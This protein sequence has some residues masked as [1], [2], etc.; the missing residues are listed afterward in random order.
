M[1][2]GIIECFVFSVLT[3]LIPLDPDKSN[4]RITVMRIESGCPWR[5]KSPTYEVFTMLE[6]L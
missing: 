3:T 4:K 2:L 6:M 1:A 5:P